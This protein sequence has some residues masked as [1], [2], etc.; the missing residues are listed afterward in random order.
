MPFR[1]L[2][3]AWLLVFGFIVPPDSGVAASK[4]FAG[5]RIIFEEDVL[6]WTTKQGVDELLMRIK[7]AG[8]N[9]FSPVVWH[10]RG[11]TWPSIFAEWDY[12]LKAYPK[13]GYDPLKYL[14]DRAHELG[15]EVHPWFTLTLREGEFLPQF[16]PSGTP[17]RGVRCPHAGVSASDGELGC[18]G[19]QPI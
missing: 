12:W 6:A 10:G 2:L 5:K 14:I 11:T 9:A 7:T 1:L 8:F 17:G 13:Q 18:G 4:T 3:F 19:R 15:I 16:A